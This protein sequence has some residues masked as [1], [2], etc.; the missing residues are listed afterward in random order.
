M[1]GLIAKTL[2]IAFLMITII[3]IAVNANYYG[4]DDEDDFEDRPYHYRHPYNYYR[5]RH[6]RK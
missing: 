3:S 5:R 4:E 6:H 2:L 1:S